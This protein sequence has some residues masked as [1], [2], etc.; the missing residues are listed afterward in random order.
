MK[1]IVKYQIIDANNVNYGM[2]FENGKMVVSPYIKD[3]EVPLGGTASNEAWMRVDVR[4]NKYIKELFPDEEVTFE[5]ICLP[6]LYW[7]D[8]MAL[9]VTIDPPYFENALS[10]SSN[11]NQPILE[12]RHNGDIFVKGKLVEND[13][14]VVNAMR[15]FLKT[16][17][18]LT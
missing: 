2:F 9:S 18:F 17:G 15:E 5:F 1:I 16:Q 8:N 12:L 10:F 14:D 4:A 3:R 13:K 6:E 11:T 7:K